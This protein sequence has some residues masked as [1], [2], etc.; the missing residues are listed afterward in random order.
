MTMSGF[1][2]KMSA[3]FKS[4]AIISICIIGFIFEFIVELPFLLILGLNHYFRKPGASQASPS[5]PRLR[6]CM[7]LEVESENRKV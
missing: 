4:L 7:S 1:I 5:K 3:F 2:K 6:R